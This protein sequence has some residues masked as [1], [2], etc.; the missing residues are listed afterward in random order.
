[1]AERV[2]RQTFAPKVAGSSP[3]G[4]LC[5]R[6]G[7]KSLSGLF[8]MRAPVAAAPHPVC[9]YIPLAKPTAMRVGPPAP[10]LSVVVVFVYSFHE[11]E[12][13]W[14]VASHCR[15]FFVFF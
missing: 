6:R 8:R 1:M 4:A 9:L 2:G 11:A 13:G 10:Q 15:F 5:E 7:E 14:V 12:D 3:T